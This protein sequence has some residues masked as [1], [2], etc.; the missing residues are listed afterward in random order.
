MKNI[1]FVAFASLVFA[2]NEKPKTST[3]DT[4]GVTNVENVNGSVPDTT[5]GTT[6]NHTPPQDSS[7]LKDSLKR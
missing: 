4:P 7:K 1:I 5:N 2:C 6:L 3:G